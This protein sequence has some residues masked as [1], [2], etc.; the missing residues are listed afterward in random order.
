MTSVPTSAVGSATGAYESIPIS[1]PRP[2]AMPAM[3]RF[4]LVPISDTEPAR[5]VTCAT[6]SRHL[7][8]RDASS[9]LELA[10][11]GDQHRDQGRRVHQ[12]RRHPD[13][14]DQPSERL[15]S[16]MGRREEQPAEAG[17]HP[18]LD[19]PLGEDEHGADGD[20]ALGSRGPTRSSSTVA[21]PRMPASTRPPARAS[22]GGTRRDAMATSVPVT[23]AAATAIVAS[24]LT[25]AP[26]EA[27]ADSSQ[28]RAVAQ[29]IVDLSSLR[30]PHLRIVRGA[31][32]QRNMRCCFASGSF[33]GG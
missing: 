18:G 13:R 24:A 31:S 5:V 30:R 19:D 22:T 28:P 15:A 6:G 7:P 2:A 26:R 33:S 20:D 9:L 21:S 3:R 10:R 23:T 1:I 25:S 12:R 14:G 32:P 17:H 29:R 27:A 4:E 8:R 11:G 16:A